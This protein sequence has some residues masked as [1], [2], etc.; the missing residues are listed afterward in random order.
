VQPRPQIPRPRPLPDLL[1]AWSAEKE[2][3]TTATTPTAAPVTFHSTIPILRVAQLERSVD[4]YLRVLG[5]T[6]DWRG[7]VMASLSRGGAS[8]M[9]CEGDQGN[10]R[11]W[12]WCGV[13]DAE[14]LCREFTAAGATIRLPLTNYWWAL[15]FHVE[16]PDGHVLRF[17]SGPK[18]DQP[19][20]E[21]VQWYR[22]T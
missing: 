6:V 1:A 19:F 4:F 11:T 12:V 20:V 3:M 16:D 2:I 13:S 8:V 17:G 5:F 9:L 22:E 21:W 15:E 18:P 10:P 14:A 7:G